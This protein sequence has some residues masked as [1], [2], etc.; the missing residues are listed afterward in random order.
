MSARAM[1][2]QQ[3]HQPIPL[4][5]TGRPCTHGNITA[6]TLQD[7]LFLV[8]YDCLQLESCLGSRVLRASLDPLLQHPLPAECQR[9]IK[10]KLAQVCQGLGG[11][12][13]AVG[14]GRWVLTPLPISD[15][16]EWHPRGA[17]AAHHLAGLPLLPHRD[18]P[19][20]HHIQGHGHGSA[21]L[22]RGPGE[23]DGG[24]GSGGGAE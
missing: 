2:E 13:W 15:L 23:P 20:E 17:A 10:A 14:A 1:A 11:S 19:V 3:D 7:D 6:A 21:G 18:W 22:G 9:V 12:G 8:H 5:A 24:E 4:P 16:P